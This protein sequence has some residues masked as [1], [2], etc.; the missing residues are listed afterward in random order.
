MSRLFNPSYLHSLFF[1]RESLF[2]KSSGK[3][4]SLRFFRMSSRVSHRVT[5]RVPLSVACVPV[6]SL[7]RRFHFVIIVGWF[8]VF[9]FAC[10]CCLLYVLSRLASRNAL[11]PVSRRASS[12]CFLVSKPSYVSYFCFCLFVHAVLCTFFRV[13]H[14]ITPCV[15]RRVARVLI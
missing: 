15:P 8:L 11:R 3:S 6:V 14:R 13:S 10:R 5:R 2:S 9:C 4:L 12:R 7:S 1:Y